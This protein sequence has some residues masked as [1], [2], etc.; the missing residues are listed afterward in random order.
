MGDWSS[1]VW[2]DG[3]WRGDNLRSVGLSLS[4][5]GLGISLSLG[6]IGIGLSLGLLGVSLGL[7]LSLDLSLSF[8]L[9]L[10]L[11][12]VERAWSVCDGSGNWGISLSWNLGG[13]S[14]WS[15]GSS[16]SSEESDWS[17]RTGDE[18]S[19]DE[20]CGCWNVSP[21]TKRT[22]NN[23][24]TDKRS[25]HNCGWLGGNL[26]G[27]SLLLLSLGGVMGNEWASLG[28]L[29]DWASIDGVNLLNPRTGSLVLVLCVRAGQVW[30]LFST[31]LIVVSGWVF[32]VVALAVGV[33][34]VRAGHERTGSGTNWSASDRSNNLSL[35]RNGWNNLDQIGVEVEVLSLL[36]LELEPVKSVH[37]GSGL[38]GGGV[39]DE[40]VD[41]SVVLVLED[42]GGGEVLAVLGDEGVD[43]L[44]SEILWEVGQEEGVGVEWVRGSWGWEEWGDLDGESADLSA[45]VGVDEGVGGLLGGELSEAL[46]DCVSVLV[47]DDHGV[48]DW[49]SGGGELGEVSGS[50][51]PVEVVDKDD[52]SWGGLVLV[53]AHFLYF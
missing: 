12:G 53:G 18:G 47:E 44:L 38:L 7:N 19:V 1:G 31:N 37:S 45:V 28:L 39:V 16:L 36:D 24:V 48:V 51:G 9:G 3:G 35:L 4:G 40:G 10:I 2:E 5:V 32:E 41:D 26:L 14:G 11:G 34:L 15:N 25:S 33:S 20:L 42:V 50:D 27:W 22:S 52:E 43:V 49:A 6:S 30:A 46:A 29:G 23:S 13:D 8:S 17:V 21:Q